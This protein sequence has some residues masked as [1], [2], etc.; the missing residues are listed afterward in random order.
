MNLVKY[1][2]LGEVESGDDQA[3]RFGNTD[4]SRAIRFTTVA[5]IITR[6]LSVVKGSS[7]LSVNDAIIP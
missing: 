4:E 2:R 3:D 7:R 6:L 5:D 1:L